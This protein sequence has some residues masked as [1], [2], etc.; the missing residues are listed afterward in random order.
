LRKKTVRFRMV[1]EAITARE[2]MDMN[3][4]CRRGQYVSIE[5]ERGAKKGRT[6]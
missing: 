5:L 2:D 1:R 6:Q 4:L 3:T